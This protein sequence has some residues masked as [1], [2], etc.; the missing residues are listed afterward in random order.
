MKYVGDVLELWKELDIDDEGGVTLDELDHSTARLVE[1]FR[2][3]VAGLGGPSAAFEVLDVDGNLSLT[4]EEFVSE[5]LSHGFVSESS[6]HD[7]TGVFLALDMHNLGHIGKEELA[8][9]DPS[10]FPHLM[11]LAGVDDEVTIKERERRLVTSRRKVVALRTLEQF[12][13]ALRKQYGHLVRAWRRLLDVDGNMYVTKT[14]LFKAC[15]AIGFSRN[16]RFLWSALD[17]DGNGLAT[18]EE[19]DVRAALTLGRFRTFAVAR[20]GSCV[21]LFQALDSDQTGRYGTR[22]LCGKGKLNIDEF[23]SNMR[24]FGYPF[25][26]LGYIFK[27]LDLSGVGFV[28]QSDV[29]FLDVWDPPQ[30]LVVKPDPEAAEQFKTCLLNF[31]PNYIQAW[32]KLLDRNETNRVTWSDFER[33]CFTLGFDG[34]VPGAWRAF[35]GRCVGFIALRQLDAVMDEVLC[36]FK[37]WAENTFGSVLNAFDV[38][39]SDGSGTLTY[40]EFKKAT[41]DHHFAGNCRLLME[42]LDLN[43]RRKIRKQDVRFLADWDAQQSAVD[44]SFLDEL[45]DGELDGMLRT[46]LFM[47]TAAAPTTKFWQS[48]SEFDLAAMRATSLPAMPVLQPTSKRTSTTPDRPSSNLSAVYGTPLR[49][50]ARRRNPGSATKSLPSLGFLT[51]LGV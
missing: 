15:K 51:K 26:N 6:A 25:G 23:L 29:V 38:M 35:D 14:E 36:E 41:T 11:R 40:R 1:H 12:R 10:A 5:C 46:G 48:R 24:R 42:S 28:H 18:L 45:E 47:R 21:G 39:D 34:S 33:A 37:L 8:W 2:E 30:W 3:F 17:A 19:L 44:M 27:A 4:R 16:L 9:I 32:R 13:Q 22:G 50:R 49:K 43:G 7:L 20:F 31:F